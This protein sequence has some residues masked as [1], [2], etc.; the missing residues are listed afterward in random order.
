M[1]LHVETDDLTLVPLEL[2]EEPESFF[3]AG[4][5]ANLPVERDHEP[6]LPVLER[7]GPPPFRRSNFPLLGFLATVYEH[8]ASHVRLTPC[9]QLGN[10]K[11]RE[12]TSGK[13]T[14]G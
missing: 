2:L 5:D 11:D 14:A 8:V 1:S 9:S 7:L 4:P 3:R 12:S 6:T 10:S 13:T